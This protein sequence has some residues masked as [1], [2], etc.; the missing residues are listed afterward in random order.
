MEG[1]GQG[2]W[3]QEE[4]SISSFNCCSEQYTGGQRWDTVL[5]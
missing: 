3:S 4:G 1:A 5:L 2:W